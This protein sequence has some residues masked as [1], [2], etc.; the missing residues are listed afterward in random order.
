M[1]LKDFITK[2]TKVKGLTIVDKI[3]FCYVIFTTILMLIYGSTMERYYELL[4]TRAAAVAVIGI[5]CGARHLFPYRVTKLFSDVV[6]MLFLIFWYQEVYYFCSQLPYQDH[7]FAEIEWQLFGCQPSLEFSKHVTSTFWSEAFNCGYYSYYYM[8]FVTIFFYGLCR[9][10]EADRAEFIF[11]TSF[12]LFYVIYELLPVAGPYYYFKAI[13]IEAANSGIYPDLGHYFQT[14]HDMLHAPVKGIFSQLV[15]NTQEFGELPA[16]A[17]PSS[18]CGMTVIT[19]IL[20]WQTRNRWLFYLM[21][22]LAI[23]L[24]MATVYIMAHYLIDTMA[25]I[26]FAFLFYYLTNYMYHL[27]HQGV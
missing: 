25:G 19:M 17:F 2:D 7:I 1:D 16:A 14:N 12:F 11:L 26:V 13:G 21:L 9:P 15:H 27:Y 8:M 22:P 5:L 3:T 23:L 6:V 18:H 24:C 20:A 10:K 4:I